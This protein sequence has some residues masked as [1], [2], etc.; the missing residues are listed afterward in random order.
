MRR[1][2]A[3][4]EGLAAEVLMSR[5]GML[6]G[7][8][9]ALPR[10]GVPWLVRAEST[11]QKKKTWQHRTGEALLLQERW[12]KSSLRRLAYPM[13]RQRLEPAECPDH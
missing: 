6:D 12:H 5:F 2:E 13:V 4:D 9:P 11:L 10:P 1:P 8:C 7:G 3:E